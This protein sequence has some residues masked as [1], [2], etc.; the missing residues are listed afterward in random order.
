MDVA[1]ALI[2]P[3]IGGFLFVSETVHFKFKTAR[4]DG[5]RLYF[6]VSYYG[7]VLFLASALIYFGFWYFRDHLPWMVWLHQQLVD[8][9]GP[10]L[11]EPARASGYVRFLCICAFSVLIGRWLPPIINRCTENTKPAKRAV[12]DAASKDELEDLLVEA[13]SNQKAIQVTMSSGKVYVGLPIG[14]AE[15]RAT[16]RAIA[17][18]PLISGYRDEKQEVEFTTHYDKAFDPNKPKEANNFR[19]V[20]PADK[21]VSAAFFDIQ[22]YARFN[23]PKIPPVPQG[24]ASALLAAPEDPGE[25]FK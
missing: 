10:A 7:F 4:E 21:I 5:H 1:L 15:P 22:T 20:L 23:V 14:T 18:L 19:L 16:R 25:T 11:K 3:L 17:M 6:R 12:K 24:L 8:F 9:I 2:L 13:V